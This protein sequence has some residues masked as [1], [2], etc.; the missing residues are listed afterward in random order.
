MEAEQVNI[1]NTPLHIDSTPES[2]VLFT[3]TDGSRK[4]LNSNDNEIN[5]I[6]STNR[7]QILNNAKKLQKDTRENFINSIK[8]INNPFAN[9]SHNNNTNSIKKISLS[10]I[11]IFSILCIAIFVYSFALFVISR[12]RN[13]KKYKSIINNILLSIFIVSTILILVSDTTANIILYIMGGSIALLLIVFILHNLYI[14]SFLLYTVI[15]DIGLKY[16]IY[17]IIFIFMFII[18]LI[19]DIV[20]GNL[21]S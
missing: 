6:Q 15:K 1:K 17:F 19:A 8:E 12:Y 18:V 13:I 11:E 7:E 21:F 4:F 5:T 2:S 3:H 10:K 16:F 9:T 20:Y 14:L